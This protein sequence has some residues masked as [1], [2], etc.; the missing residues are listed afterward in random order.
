MT[1]A[2]KRGPLAVLAA[3]L[4]AGTFLLQFGS[5]IGM[6]LNL[7]VTAFDTSTLLDENDAF[8]GTYPCGT[9]AFM[10]VDQDGIPVD[11]TVF[12]LEDDLI[13]DCPIYAF[14]TTDD[15]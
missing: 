1:R 13:W 12:G 10:I 5:C 8:F 9:P 4:V 6:A 7:G 3:Y 11:E 14:V 2:K 15:G